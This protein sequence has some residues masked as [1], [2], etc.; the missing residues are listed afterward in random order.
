MSIM[1][2]TMYEK[3]VEK[4]NQIC[5]KKNSVFS[6]FLKKDNFLIMILVGILLL[7]IVWPVNTGEEKNGAELWEGQE[8]TEDNMADTY[9]VSKSSEEMIAKGAEETMLAY[10]TYLEE[11]LEEVLSSMEG[12]G[13][14]KVMVTMESSGEAVIEKDVVT[15]RSGTTEVDSAGGSRNTTDISRQEETVFE[16][17]K[18]HIQLPYVKRIDAP[19]VKGVLI[20]AQ[21]GHNANV[22]KNI[23]EAI[24]ALFG[25]EVHKIKIVK[26]NS[27]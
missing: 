19:K 16:E 20:A 4:K 23:T 24:Q 6:V 13:K 15:Q 5:G 26:M 12:A 22:A 27:Q 8:D 7:V 1:D 18:E 25:I 3:E 2:E 21:G 9:S 17:S 10:A 14:V 11:T